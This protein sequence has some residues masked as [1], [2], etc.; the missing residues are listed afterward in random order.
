[1]PIVP[2]GDPN[3]S[4][5]A[6]DTGR[7]L[8]LYRHEGANMRQCCVKAC[9]FFRSVIAIVPLQD[10]SFSSILIVEPL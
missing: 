10:E 7:M 6:L 3:F 1:M 8:H 9:S 5:S 4:T 2:R